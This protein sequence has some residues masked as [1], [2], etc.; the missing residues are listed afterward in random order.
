MVTLPVVN[1]TALWYAVHCRAGS[2]AQASTALR[3]IHG[4]A[5]YMPMLT[6]RV[7]GGKRSAPFFPGYIFV[8]TQLDQVPP[9][10]INATPGVIRLVSFGTTP[11]AVPPAVVQGIRAYVEAFNAGGGTVQLFQPG[12][13]VRIRGGALHGLD[14][15]FLDSTHPHERVRILVEFL[16][17]QCVAHVEVGQLERSGPRPRAPHNQPRG[18]RGRGR[19]IR[20]R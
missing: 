12:D 3:D 7:R 10:R 5:T 8:L 4:V 14:G 2:E 19:T 11:P 15:L 20:Y 17:Q 1:D 6:W 13:S 16:G 9:S 18:T